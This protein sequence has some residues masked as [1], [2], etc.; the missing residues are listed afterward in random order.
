MG[1]RHLE[2]SF[3]TSGG[4]SVGRFPKGS[5]RGSGTQ[6][7]TH[8]Q[9]EAVE[10]WCFTRVTQRCASESFLATVLL[11]VLFWAVFHGFHKLPNI[12]QYLSF[13]S[14]YIARRDSVIC[15]YLDQWQAWCNV[16][17]DVILFWLCV[18]LCHLIWG[19]WFSTGSDFSSS[20]GMWQCLQTLR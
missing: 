1:K 13:I 2:R 11:A 4:R 15:D 19:Q 9:V 10:R 12:W 17:R 7:R 14:D 20:G 8:C 18:C 3:G 6:S 16:N 5:C